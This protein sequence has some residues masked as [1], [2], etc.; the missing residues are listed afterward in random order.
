MSQFV[1]AMAHGALGE[2]QPHFG[3]RVTPVGGGKNALGAR[4]TREDA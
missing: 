2:G 4:V 3:G 1:Q